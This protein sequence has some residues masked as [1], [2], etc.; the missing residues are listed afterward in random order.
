MDII[1]SVVSRFFPVAVY[2]MIDSTSDAVM[3]P[4]L[5][6]SHAR[7]ALCCHS[8]FSSFLKIGRGFLP[9]LVYIGLS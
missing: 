3:K 8:M 6:V 9:D 4:D 7:L 5:A 2:G 1:A